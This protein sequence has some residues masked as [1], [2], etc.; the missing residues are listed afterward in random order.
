MR[1]AK[2]SPSRRLLSWLFLPLLLIAAWALYRMFE[3]V[4]TWSS[5]WQ[6]LPTADV[7]FADNA[8]TSDPAWANVAA[9]ADA[10]LRAARA[11]LQA[12]A[13]SAAIMVGGQRVWA[14]A[15]GFADIAQS[16]TVDLD[17]GFRLGS[18]SK[19]INALA[20]GRLMDAGKL[21]I[22]RSVR[23]Y[24]PDLP[25]TYDA[26]TTR[27]AISHTAGVPDYSLCLCFPIWE[28][29]N[30]RHF[31]GV[32]DALRVFENRPL[33][34]A[35][36][37]GFHYSSYGANVAGAVVEAVARR[38]YL[39]AVND[40]VFKP[41]AMKH[42]RG[43]VATAANAHEVVFYEVVEGKYKPADPVDNSIRYP[44]GGLLSTPSD[45]LAVGS[46]FIGGDFLSDATRRRLLTRQKLRN[47]SDN[48]QG[49]ALGI[50][51]FD[52]KKL[53]DD[54]VQTRFYSH[55]GTAVG[56]TSYFGVYPE[57]GLVI[58]M[59]MNKGQENLDAMAVEANRL[60]ELFIAEQ[61]RRKRA[62]ANDVA[63]R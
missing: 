61:I 26:V 34:F 55:H 24:V 2:N 12:P 48:P 1:V 39:D 62:N 23:D 6:P 8:R 10:Q 43:D 17:S 45:M 40:S 21:D 37:D 16:R 9:Q 42:S 49:Y 51:V 18:S 58:S 7:G 32:R 20:M 63:A 3:P 28:H 38:P 41:L 60:A 50:R 36:G 31:A 53:F 14:A 47:G 52:D 22:D 33:L 15:T 57:Y 54:S 59:M 25:A 11:R 27:L 13:M 29:K 35:P 46:A 4:L 30:R 44:S 56:S 5:G 19:A